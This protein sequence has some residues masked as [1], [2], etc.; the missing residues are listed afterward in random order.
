[1]GLFNKPLSE[2]STGEKLVRGVILAGV[3]V[4]LINLF[5]NKE[6][7]TETKVASAQSSTQAVSAKT[8]TGNG[9]A[10]QSGV[11]DT[12]ITSAWSYGNFVDK[13]SGETKERY[14]QLES[15]NILNLKFPYSGGV[16]A[17][18]VVYHIEK[19]EPIGYIKLSKGMFDE[20]IRR[21]R[22]DDGKVMELY[23]MAE[24]SV[25]DKERGHMTLMKSSYAPKDDFFAMLKK[26][27]HLRFEVPIYDNGNQ[28]LEF[29]T[30]GLDPAIFPDARGG[31]H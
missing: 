15:D 26:S 7:S 29:S 22:F 3:V 5:S 30:A 23:P 8:N 25:S 16:T 27:K 12:T 1:M 14:A 6:P 31:K 28:I 2:Q 4:T 11:A 19:N 13:M 9:A 17:E 24:F 21:I 10:V 20:G 18:L